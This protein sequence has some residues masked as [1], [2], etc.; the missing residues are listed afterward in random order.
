[1][2]A[3]DQGNRV[4]DIVV[5]TKKPALSIGWAGQQMWDPALL[6]RVLKPINKLFHIGEFLGV[7]RILS[8][9]RLERIKDRLDSCRIDPKDDTPVSSVFLTAS[10]RHYQQQNNQAV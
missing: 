3:L 1:M 9:E 8:D 6:A 5:C 4:C 2:F 10:P 7:Y